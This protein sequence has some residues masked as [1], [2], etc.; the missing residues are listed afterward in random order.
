MALLFV[1]AWA[2]VIRTLMIFQKVGEIRLGGLS[3][4]CSSWL[5]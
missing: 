5:V 2:Y 4:F 1:L 3:T